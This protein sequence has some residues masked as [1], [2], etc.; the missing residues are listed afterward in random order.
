MMMMMMM[1]TPN[2]PPRPPTTPSKN[3]YVEMRNKGL[4]LYSRRAGRYADAM[5]VSVPLCLDISLVFTGL[6]VR[7]SSQRTPWIQMDHCRLSRWSAITLR[8]RWLYSLRIVLLAV[9]TCLPSR[10]C[11]VS[12]ST[13]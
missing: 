13:V 8:Q 9:R 1:I 3:N 7:S 10:S 4:F 11:T 5:A 6:L 12:C 2:P